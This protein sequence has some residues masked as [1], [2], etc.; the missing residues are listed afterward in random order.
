MKRAMKRSVTSLRS[1]RR[2]LARRGF[3]LVELL[4]TVAMIGVLAAIGIVGY[5]K[6]V[7][8]AQSAEAK[9]MI[10]MIKGAE[11][12]FKGEFLTYLNV[13]SS[14]TDYY[15]NTTPDDSRWAWV[16][17]ND[18]RYTTAVTACTKGMCGGWSV[19][20]IGADAPVRFGYAVIAG[21]GGTP[22]VPPALSPAPSMPTLAAGIPWY[23]VQATNKHNPGSIRS[24]VFASSSL[25]SEIL[26]QDEQE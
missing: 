22:T 20:N 26:M 10:S 8:S 25:S 2:R 11:D 4:I 14:L 15:P 5:R 1:E 24:A 18:G 12:N 6:Y 3:T 17:P 23:V 16:Q 19:L 13:S 21:I 9:A 7:H